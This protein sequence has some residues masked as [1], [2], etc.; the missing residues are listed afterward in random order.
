MKFE[1]PNIVKHQINLILDN[2]VIH[3]N[4]HRDSTS[5]ILDRIKKYSEIED[6]FI[7][8]HEHEIISFYFKLE[9]IHDL[10]DSL[11]NK[12][13][14]Q[15]SSSNE[16]YNGVH[17]LVNVWA[18][19]QMTGY[20]TTDY[21]YD[22]SVA[23]LFN[24][25]TYSTFDR[26][27]IDSKFVKSIMSSR[28]ATNQRDYVFNNINQDDIEINRYIR[29]TNEEEVFEDVYPNER[30]STFPNFNELL[31]EYYSSIFS[32]IIETDYFSFHDDQTANMFFRTGP[33]LSEKTI[34][35]FITGTIPIILGQKHLLH[36]LKEM[37]FWVANDDF[38]YS[39]ADEYI[40]HIIKG[41]RFVK[42]IKNVKELSFDESRQYWLDNKDKIYN[43]WNIISSLFNYT[44][45]SLL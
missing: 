16:I 15:S 8:L 23:I 24:K 14:I 42:C 26:V 34:I 40:S 2:K 10:I 22:D 41:N 4:E 35:P 33:Q 38:G 28:T 3:Y 43:N 32:F 27:N 1:L 18:W 7:I 45:K 37:G 44:N 17:P 20:I 30:L 9:S 25:N 13:Y 21:F 39:D 36:D 19:S 31:D 6:E 5:E 29:Y 11:D 12:I